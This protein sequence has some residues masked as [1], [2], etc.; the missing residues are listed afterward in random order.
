MA[1]MQIQVWKSSRTSIGRRWPNHAKA[2]AGV[3]DAGD[4]GGECRNDVE[5]GKG[6]ESRSDE[7][8]LTM[9]MKAKESTANRMG[10]GA[11]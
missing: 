10:C 2:R 5:A 6:H 11:V 1:K 4:D 9:Y 7:T 8:I 3:V